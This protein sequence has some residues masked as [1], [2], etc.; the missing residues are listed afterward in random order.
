M[1]N[2][3]ANLPQELYPLA[4]LVGDWH[5]WAALTAEE[6]QPLI[7]L[8]TSFTVD[9]TALREETTAWKTK[10]GVDLAVAASAEDGWKALEKTEELY[11]ETTLWSVEGIRELPQIDPATGRTTILSE[12]KVTSSGGLHGLEVTWRGNGQG[13]RLGLAADFES[14]TESESE[15]E[16]SPN[17]YSQPT[18]KGDLTELNRMYGLVMGELMWA[19]DATI[20]GEADTELAVR[21]ARVEPVEPA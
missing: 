4:W 1:F 7:V 15:G 6:G 19:Q 14:E 16:A 3:E 2:I 9:G 21:L 12:L 10:P 20:N 13:P 5:G 17:E 8:E 18:E 11:R